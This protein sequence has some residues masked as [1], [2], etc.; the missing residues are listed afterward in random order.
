MTTVAEER[1]TIF[2]QVGTACNAGKLRLDPLRVSAID[3]VAA[4]GFAAA[5]MA[6]RNAI[7][8]ELVPLLLRAKFSSDTQAE[9]RALPLFAAWLCARARLAIPITDPRLPAPWV[10]EQLALTTVF[11]QR[12]IYE[13]INDRCRGCNGSGLQERIGKGGRRAPKLYIRNNMRLLPCAACRGSGYARDNHR[14]RA[15]ALHCTPL[16][17][18]QDEWANRFANGRSWLAELA[19]RA[20]RP[21]HIAMS[22][23]KFR[24]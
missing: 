18:R 11:A 12:L 8:G 19:S 21:L 14:A 7:E 15:I 1:A 6:R 5:R 13:W 9:I 10:A 20:E 24:A 4:I 2:E 16:V 17:Y 22:H 3:L 23:G